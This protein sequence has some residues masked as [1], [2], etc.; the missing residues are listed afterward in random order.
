MRNPSRS[1][2]ALSMMVVLPAVAHNS[3]LAQGGEGDGEGGNAS[4]VPAQGGDG[5][6]QADEAEAPG[7]AEQPVVPKAKRRP[8]RVAS[9][10]PRDTAFGGPAQLNHYL[11][12]GLS[13]MPGSGYRLIVPYKQGQF[14]GDS[15]GAAIKA[16]CSHAVPFFLDIQLAFGASPRVDIIADIRFGAQSDPLFPG[17]HQFALAPGVRFWLDQEVTLK[18]YATLQMVYDYLDFHGTGPSNSDFG[19]RNA[20]GLMYDPIRNVGFFFQ[21]GENIEF[22]R[23]FSIGLDVGL[24]A[25]IRFP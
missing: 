18:F 13:I 16:V 23:W 15:S 2:I 7:E 11:Q 10:E 17:G 21:F 3:A 24:G 5:P 9:T 14:C 8:K 25:Q 6:A 12:T 1:V 22:A 20:N 4:Q 19:V